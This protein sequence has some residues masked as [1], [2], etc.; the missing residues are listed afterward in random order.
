MG[1]VLLFVLGS[2]FLAPADIYAKELSLTFLSATRRGL[3][4][5][6]LMV[7]QFLGSLLCLPCAGDTAVTK[8]A[9]F[10]PS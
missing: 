10:L 1:S 6:P 8:T 5:S 4:M 9:S 7:I 2:P 3:H